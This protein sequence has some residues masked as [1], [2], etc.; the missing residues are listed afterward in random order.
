MLL[1]GIL[2]FLYISD[3]TFV[4]MW[5]ALYKNVSLRTICYY[6]SISF[7]VC[8]EEGVLAISVEK[9]FLLLKIFFNIH[10]I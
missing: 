1:T 8:E 7:M 5:I 3:L 6:F 10:L 2:N 9:I 4:V